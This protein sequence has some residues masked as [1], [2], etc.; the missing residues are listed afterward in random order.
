[1]NDKSKCDSELNDEELS[2]QTFTLAFN[3]KFL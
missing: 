1:M 3:D 2:L